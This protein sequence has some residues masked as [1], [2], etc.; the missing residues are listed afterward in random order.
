[1]KMDAEGDFRARR[2][3]WAS[4]EGSERPQ[5]AQIRSPAAAS[6]RGVQAEQ[7]G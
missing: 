1:M 6:R 4:A 2:R 5:V 3:S 7:A